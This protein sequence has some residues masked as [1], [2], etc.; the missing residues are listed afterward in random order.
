MKSYGKDSGKLNRTCWILGID[1]SKESID[2]C[3][4][5]QLRWADLFENKFNNNSVRV[6]HL[7]R[8]V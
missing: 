6:R 4:I 2:A 5:R 7:K 3:L 1:V 8:L